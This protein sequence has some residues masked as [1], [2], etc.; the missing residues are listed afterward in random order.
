MKTTYWLNY[1]KTTFLPKLEKIQS[2]RQKSFVNAEICS[3]Y[4]D[5]VIISCTLL[6]YYLAYNGLFQFNNREII[7][8]AFY[9]ELIDDGQYWI[10]SLSLAVIIKKYGYQ[11]VKSL[12]SDYLKDDHFYIFEN[13]NKNFEKYMEK[14]V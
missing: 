13:L 7:R 9:V 8:E 14:Y 6:Q 2:L 11:R 4:V 5:F 12:M 1:Y 3:E 10:N